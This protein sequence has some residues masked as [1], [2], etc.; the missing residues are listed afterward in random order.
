MGAVIF[1]ISL[2]NIR[3]AAGCKGTPS[4]L[5][6]SSSFKTSRFVTDGSEDRRGLKDNAPVLPLPRMASS[7]PRDSSASDSLE[8]A[9]RDII[10]PGAAQ[11]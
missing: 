9:F 3:C 4:T 11:D 6:A 5:L 1:V 8:Q 2:G 7:G 10:H